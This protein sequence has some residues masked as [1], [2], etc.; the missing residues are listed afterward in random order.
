MTIAAAA[1]ELRG[2][3]IYVPSYSRTED[4]IFV[5][6][7]W[8]T[9]LNADAESE[10]L[11]AAIIEALEQSRDNIPRPSREEIAKNYSNLLRAAGVRS[12]T[13]YMAGVRK[14]N[15]S[16]DEPDNRIE[17]EPMKNDGPRRGFSELDE[18]V[19]FLDAEASSS[20]IG[21]ATRTALNRSL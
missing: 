19:I 2:Q 7:G 1:V 20:E 4:G 18:G 12:N 3:H 16:R 15:I 13:Q 10:A 9:Q 8:L 5:I 6:N 17:L 21:Q 11:G 14:V